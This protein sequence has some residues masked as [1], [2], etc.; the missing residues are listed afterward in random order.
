MG[1]RGHVACEHVHRAYSLPLLTHMRGTV[2]SI[3]ADCASRICAGA[4][5]AFR[6][7]L[8]ERCPRIHSSSVHVA[9]VP[10]LR[11]YTCEKLLALQDTTGASGTLA[12]QNAKQP[13]RASQPVIITCPFGSC[14]P[15]TDVSRFRT[16]NLPQSFT[17]PSRMPLTDAERNPPDTCTRLAFRKRAAA[18]VCRSMAAAQWQVAESAKA[19]VRASAPHT[20]DHVARSDVCASV[21][22]GSSG[23]VCHVLPELGS[24]QA[25]GVLQNQS[26]IPLGRGGFNVPH[27]GRTEMTRSYRPYEVDATSYVRARQRVRA[28]SER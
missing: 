4:A 7:P 25:T 10:P 12:L 6:W 8:R 13:H 21:P 23:R 27:D 17:Q 14:D 9:H 18:D 11:I 5:L 19:K 3:A 22:C 28:R 20:H 16:F 15:V 2:S 24:S 26:T 1:N